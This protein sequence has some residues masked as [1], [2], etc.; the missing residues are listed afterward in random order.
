MR[1]RTAVT[2]LTGAAA[3]TVALA[4]S[5][6]AAEGSIFGGNSTNNASY[7]SVRYHYEKVGSSYTAYL[8]DIKV[9]DLKYGDGWGSSLVVRSDQGVLRQY[10]VHD[11][12]HYSFG[13]QTFYRVSG[14]W[15]SI[16]NW[17]EATDALNSCARLTKTG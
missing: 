7:A 14:V 16:C 8:H 11:S 9:G 2:A 10:R 3:L 13:D 1:L 4:G 15:F 17:N 6:Q 5:A 12:Q